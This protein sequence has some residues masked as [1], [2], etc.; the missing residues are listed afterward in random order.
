MTENKNDLMLCGAEGATCF[1]RSQRVAR[2]ESR[3][4]AEPRGHASC[5]GTSHARRSHTVGGAS[6]RAPGEL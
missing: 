1:G 5:G 6:R 4:G 2:N 3:R